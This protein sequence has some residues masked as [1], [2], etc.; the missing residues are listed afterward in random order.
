MT[1]KDST[2]LASILVTSLVLVVPILVL[3]VD[4][5]LLVI[6]PA[7]GI[8]YVIYCY[9]TERVLTGLISAFF[10]LAVFGANIPLFDGPD[11]VDL[12]LYIMDLLAVVL[13]AVIIDQSDLNIWQIS[14]SKLSLAAVLGL[15][16]FVVWAFVA[17]AVG[18]G[19]SQIA[20]TIFAVQQM[21][22]LVMFLTGLFVVLQTK[23]I[24]GLYP[25]LISIGGNVLYALGEVVVG[26]T[27]GL[28]YLGDAGGRSFTE[29]GIG[30]WI[31]ETG[32]FISGYVG[33]V[34][35]LVAITLL[36]LPFL[37]YVGMRD[38]L[39][40]TV[41]ALLSLGSV[42]IVIRAGAT[43]AGLGASI[44]TLSVMGVLLLCVCSTDGVYSQLRSSLL[45]LFAIVFSVG[46]YR[47]WFSMR[48]D[49]SKGT[50]PTTPEPQGGTSEPTTTTPE[51][52]GGT[53][54]PTTIIG[55]IL[56]IFPVVEINTLSIRLTQYAAAIHIAIAYP[57]FGIGGYNFALLS[58]EYNLPNGMDIHNQYLA[59]L[60]ATGLPGLIAYMVSIGSVFTLLCYHLLR[61]EEQ[62]KL[63]YTCLICSLIGFHAYSFWVTSQ[64]FIIPNIAFWLLSGMVIGSVLQ[65]SANRRA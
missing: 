7:V 39:R 9:W 62:Y 41:F 8:G 3:W 34:R 35:E 29:F 51:P 17:A 58:Q 16:A 44:L 15:A 42:A 59:Y 45:N 61:G 37:V 28:T 27:F 36:L 64:K 48:G 19:P 32:F 55:D 60:A 10:V 33:N 18:N 49:M 53:S 21:R 54:E 26:H 25:L 22:Y 38:G 4:V 52:Q 2:R 6:L 20:A 14:Y 1:A 43:D 30:P 46:L 57:V 31:F 56:S 11:K 23:L 63:V 24:V 50:N 12:S 65:T 40:N 5:P 13:L 47:G